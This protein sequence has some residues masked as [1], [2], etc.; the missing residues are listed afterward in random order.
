MDTDQLT[1]SPLVH[2]HLSYAV[3]A[4]EDLTMHMYPQKEAKS[5]SNPIDVTTEEQVSSLVVAVSQLLYDHRELLFLAL[6]NYHL[7]TLTATTTKKKNCFT[8]KTRFIQDLLK[9]LCGNMTLEI[10]NP[11]LSL[12][13]ATFLFGALLYHTMNDIWLWAPS[14]I[15]PSKSV[16]P[17]CDKLYP[18]HPLT[19]SFP[20]VIIEDLI[21]RSSIWRMQK[22]AGHSKVIRR[23]STHCRSILKGSFWYGLKLRTSTEKKLFVRG[24]GVSSGADLMYFSWTSAF[25]ELR[26]H[27]D[28]L[29]YQ[30]QGC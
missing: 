17:R 10:Q 27:S 18:F 1:A 8:R 12:S 7:P 5:G 19:V 21:S 15:H 25:I 26:R 22:S 30:I 28:R 13:D 20:M 4:S 24:G 2:F 23:L 11:W 9:A 3:G 6:L 14:T 16:T 29:G